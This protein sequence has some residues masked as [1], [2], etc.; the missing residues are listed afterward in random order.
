[1]SVETEDVFC[2]LWDVVKFKTQPARRPFVEGFVPSV[3]NSYHNL[4]VIENICK[5]NHYLHV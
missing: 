4:V 1:M 3:G 2:S 5:A